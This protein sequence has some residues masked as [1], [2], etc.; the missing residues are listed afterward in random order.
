MGVGLTSLVV[1]AIVTHIRG[2]SVGFLLIFIIFFMIVWSFD[3]W[4]FASK[5]GIYK[6]RLIPKSYHELQ[7][8]QAGSSSKKWEWTD[9]VAALVSIIVW[10]L[11]AGC[12]LVVAQK[13]EEVAG[14][15]PLP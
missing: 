11:F 4:Q 1:F 2:G 13:F 12:F 7:V 8:V 15:L 14:V 10:L 3:E 6:Q 5:R 9:V